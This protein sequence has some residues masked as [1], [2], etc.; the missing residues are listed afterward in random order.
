MDRSPVIG[1]IGLGRMGGPMAGNLLTAGHPVVVY[2]IDRS[3]CEPLAA[4][5][6]QIAESPAAVAAASDVSL[7]IIMNDAV[8]R[9]VA[10]G[11]SGIVHGARPGHLYCDL[12]TVSP[13]ASAEVGAALSASGIDYLRGRVAGSIGLAEAGELTIFASGSPADFDRA[14]PVLAA[15]GKRILYVGRDEV[16]AYLKLVHSTIVGVYAALMGEALTLGEKGG[17]DFEQM[18]DILND[19]PLGSVQLALKTPMLK[20]RDFDS[21]PSDIDTAA[22]DLDIVLSAARD[23]RIPMPLTSAVRQLMTQRQAGGSG[24][25]DIWSILETFEDMAA[26]AEAPT[27]GAQR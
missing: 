14:E 27:T 19:G 22:K 6:A 5:G 25:Q 1:F 3:K 8:L 4:R 20:K 2:D 21:P 10:L 12:S 26:L 16:A 11:E 17:V 9:Q 18:L 13:A 23:Q 15:L 24:K 7:S